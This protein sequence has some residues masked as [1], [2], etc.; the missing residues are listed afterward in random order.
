[1][2]KRKEKRE[3]RREEGFL[4]EVTHAL[5]SNLGIFKAHVIALRDVS[6]LL[7]PFCA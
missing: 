6:F 2:E 7:A 3:K 4:D 1:M 5:V